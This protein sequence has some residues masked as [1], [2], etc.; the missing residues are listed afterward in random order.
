MDTHGFALC[1]IQSY[2]GFT[3]TG[4]ILEKE[5]DTMQTQTEAALYAIEELR[6][7]LISSLNQRL[8]ALKQ[9]V[10]NGSIDTDAAGEYTYPLSTT[11]SVFKGTKP[12]AV[13]FG[14]ERVDVKTWRGL[15]IEL[16]NRAYAVP[17]SRDAMMF[18]RNKVAG[19]KRLVISDKPDGM[20][21][22]V[23]LSDELYVEVYFDTEQLLKTLLF[24]VLEPAD[25][26]YSNIYVI[27]T[28]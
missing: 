16:L 21:V 22:P 15:C 12:I 14:E 5:V 18:L 20:S 7:S 28:L 25:Y 3:P 9:K 1:I 6:A 4:E 24:Q 11:P 10:L 27:I 8:D 2:T 23:R 13:V 26:D 17:Q 19:R